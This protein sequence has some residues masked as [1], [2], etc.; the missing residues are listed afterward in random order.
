MAKQLHLGSGSCGYRTYASVRILKSGRRP[1]V[2]LGWSIAAAFGV[3]STW[4]FRRL[5]GCATA[6]AS[7][8]LIG[9]AHVWT[10]VTFRGRMPASAWIENSLVRGIAVLRRDE[11]AGEG[12][13]H[14]HVERD[15][16]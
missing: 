1:R 10:V 16:V 14:V 11:R 8:A 3:S 6:C 2:V 12:V 5:S 13:V 15:Q 9:R 4:K 7:P